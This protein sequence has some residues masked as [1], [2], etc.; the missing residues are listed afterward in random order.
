SGVT[1]PSLG[2]AVH[3]CPGGCCLACLG[4]A[5]PHTRPNNSGRTDFHYGYPRGMTASKSTKV[6]LTVS[7][8]LACS[9]PPNAVSRRHILVVTNPGAA[10]STRPDG[11][12]PRRR[13]CGRRHRAGTDS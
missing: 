1:Y 9:S 13:G 2:L 10:A 5:P 6:A 7:I 12:W 4:G 11:P 3:L 8:R